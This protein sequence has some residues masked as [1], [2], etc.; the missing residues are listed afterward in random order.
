[1]SEVLLVTAV[2]SV[3]LAVLVG[4]LMPAKARAVD[5]A[6]ASLETVGLA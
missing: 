2:M 3:A 4:V 1:M 6:E 5:T